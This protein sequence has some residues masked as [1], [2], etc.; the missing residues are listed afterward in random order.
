M[1]RIP[2]HTN[3]LGWS[4][5]RIYLGALLRG[6]GGPLD[7]LPAWG[8]ALPDRVLIPTPTGRHA[9]WYFLQTAGL[10]PGDEV[11]VGAYNFYVIVR[12][13]VQKGLVPVFVDIEPKT[14]CL[15]PSDLA[16]KITPRS[17]MVLVTH[18]FGNPANLT[19]VSDL[20][21]RHDLLLFEDCAHAVGTTHAGTQVGRAG[22]GALF[23]FGVQKL[24]NTFGGGLLCLREELAERFVARLHRAGIVT[25]AL[26][27]F[28]R[29]MTSALMSPSV[30]GA[31][32]HPLERL[33]SS[34]PGSKL[35]QWIDPSKDDPAYRFSTD[36]RAPFR[37]FM[38]RM[39]VKQLGRL[40]ETIE[41]RRANVAAMKERCADANGIGLLD[42]DRHGFSNGSYFG[43]YVADARLFVR[44]LGAR[45]IGAAQEYYDC[46]RLEQ[47]ADFRAHC[48][49]A[50][51]ASGQLLRLPSHTG[52]TP[53]DRD[54][55]AAALIA[56]AAQ[57]DRA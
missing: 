17:R 40:A 54:A 56:S 16:R 35:Q 3:R 42:E 22:D 39:H 23:S 26:D 32:L 6:H 27:T 13:L 47:F 15:D 57:R 44:Q 5:Y 34:R 31:T 28:V 21:R 25:S 10:E 43:V 30:Y 20:C 9:L 38:L 52:L 36:G 18:M 50:Q 8:R 11:L 1:R 37:P 19:E 24:V 14:L 12:L 46:S 4:D 41:Q 33:A 51:R 29:F 45:G 7:A 2:K 49:G 48:P 55:I 53:D